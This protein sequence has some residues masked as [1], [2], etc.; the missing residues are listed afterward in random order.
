M[1]S[2]QKA[3]VLTSLQIIFL[4]DNQITDEGCAALASALSGGALPALYDLRLGGNPA[5]KQAQ[6]VSCEVPH[7]RARLR[8]DWEWIAERVSA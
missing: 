8:S 7:A 1:A 2:V 4:E 5:S 3:G 6:K